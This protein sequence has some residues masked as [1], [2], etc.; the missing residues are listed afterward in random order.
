MSSKIKSG[1]FFGIFTAIVLISEHLVSTNIHTTTEI[2][3]I[4]V[5]G[6]LS[7]TIGGLVFV[8][9]MEKFKSSAFGNNSTK[10][11]LDEDEQIIFQTPANHFKG[12]E[13]V[14]GKL[15]LTN[16]CLIFK[17]HKLN[18]Q[19]HELSI[20]LNKI[21]KIERYKVLSKISN[22]LKVQTVENTTERFV[23]KADEWYVHLRSL[24]ETMVA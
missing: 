24:P 4:I 13:G 17:S 16:R 19:N 1:L 14:G 3:G 20:P 12:A 23:E 8:F 18:I 2:M 10:I 22:G 11:D 6:I 7:G 9:L 21:A 5:V 15:Y